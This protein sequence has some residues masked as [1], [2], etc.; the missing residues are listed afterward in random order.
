MDEKKDLNSVSEPFKAK[1]CVG[2]MAKQKKIKF[3]GKDPAGSVQKL[4]VKNVSPGGLAGY[5][6]LKAHR[7]RLPCDS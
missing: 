2:K 6:A 3:K 5:S 1:E 4:R 7:W